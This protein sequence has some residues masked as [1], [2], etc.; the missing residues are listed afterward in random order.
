MTQ[1]LNSTKLQELVDTANHVVVIQADNPDADSLA[2]A[3]ALEAWLEN[4]NK[5]VSLFCGVDMPSYLKF[6]PG[7]DRIHNALANTFDLAILVDCSYHHTPF[8]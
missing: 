1:Q 3:L 4:Q 7:W 6:I 2:S 5:K 8:Y